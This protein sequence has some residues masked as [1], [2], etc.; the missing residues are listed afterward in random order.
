[1]TP[2][3]R[4][5]ASD[6]HCVPVAHHHPAR[7]EDIAAII[8]RAMAEQRSV[9]VA[10]AGHSFSDI[11]LT[12]GHLI[13]LD[14][15]ATVL[16]ADRESGLVKVQAGTTLRALNRRLDELGLALENLGDIDAQSLAGAVA[17]ATHGTGARLAN[18]SAQVAE[19]DLV[20]ADGTIHTVGADDPEQLR[21]ARVSLGALGVVTSLTLRCV[22]AFG[23]HAVD[24]PVP[25]AD[26][27]ADLD[28]LV[29][30]NDHFEFF[31]FPHSDLALTRTN[32]R[33]EGPRQPRSRRKAWVD[34][35]LL[36]QHVF[37]AACLAGRALPGRIPA[38]NRAVSRAVGV[39]ER[40]DRSWEIFASPRTVRFTEMEV[41][42]PREHAV[43]GIERIRALVA[44]RDFA[45]NFPI[46][47]RFV[48]GDDAFLSPA[49]GRDTC[50]LAVHVFRGMEWEPFF[51]AVA[52]ALGELGGRPH[53]GKRHF[54][55]AADLRERYP[56]WDRFAAVRAQLDPDGRF[57][58]PHTDRVLGRVAVPAGV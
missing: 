55:T 34:D 26:T 35:V 29:D 27:L 31:V 11:V 37:H 43:A 9:R 48:A 30:S 4:N 19:L 50:Y 24:A 18:L 44:E 39:S 15:M 12:N 54:G 33:T 2:M 36:G 1:M 52:E 38:I 13:E 5:W 7:D 8:A 56:E 28:S 42:I 23:L 49:A 6:Q 41:A 45:V 10:G 14:R 57:A 47:V 21:A 46:E 25:L 32:N 22:P 53:W 40:T 51:A 3:W 58:N 16:D 17:T 20:L